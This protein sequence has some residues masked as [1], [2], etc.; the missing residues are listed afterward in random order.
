VSLTKG[1]VE[2]ESVETN[3]NVEDDLSDAEE[4]RDDIAEM[5]GLLERAKQL[6]TQL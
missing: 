6:F 1:L 3:D 4:V 5:A 2:N